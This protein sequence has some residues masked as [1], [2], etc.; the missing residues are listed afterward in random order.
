M[1]RERLV[2]PAPWSMAMDLAEVR[3]KQSYEPPI[4]AGKVWVNEGKFTSSPRGRTKAEKARISRTAC[5]ELW[6]FGGVVRGDFFYALESKSE[7]GA[8]WER[9][10]GCGS[11]F[12][13]QKRVR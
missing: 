9:G 7:E 8:N 13:I 5:G 4:D 1:A 10:A 12:A 11:G 2:Q 3:G 6:R